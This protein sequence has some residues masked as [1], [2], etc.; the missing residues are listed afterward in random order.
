MATMPIGCGGQF[1]RA[2]GQLRRR[3]LR[4]AAAALVLLGCAPLV[5]AQSP[6]SSA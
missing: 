2:V 4:R 1:E 5:A 3:P 6:R